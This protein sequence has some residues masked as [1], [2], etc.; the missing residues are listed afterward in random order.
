MIYRRR[1]AFTLIEL[2]VVVSIIALLIAILLP[3]LQKAREA[4]HVAVCAANL[5]QIDMGT[6]MYAQ[7]GRGSFPLAIMVG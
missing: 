5:K 1:S 4:A 7:A 2:L 3:A 6:L